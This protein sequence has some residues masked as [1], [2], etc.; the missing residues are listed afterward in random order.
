VIFAVFRISLLRL[1]N[2]KQELLLVF[3]VPVVFFSIFAL[4]F[5]RGVGQSVAQ[6]RVAFVDDDQTS[7]SAAIIRSACERQE[8]RPVTGVGQTVDSWGIERLSKLLISRWD[9]EV[10]IYIPQGFTSQSAEA[11]TLAIELYDEGSN[12]I[13]HRLA[14]AALAESIAM[15][16]SAASLA[17]LN[18]PS[19]Q[20]PFRLTSAVSTGK[21][22][23]PHSFVED[24][25][26]EPTVFRTHNVFASNKHQPKVALVAA[27][28]AVMFLL[29]SANSA[30]ASLLEE[31]EAG[32]LDRLFTTQLSL[33]ELLLG[34]WLFMTLIGFTQLFVMFSWGQLVFNIDLL[35]R[36]PGF[37]MMAFVTAAA[38]ASFALFLA[39][40]SRSRQ[41]LHALSIVFVLSMSAVGGSMVP[42]YIMSDTMR[43]LGKLTFNGWALDG[44]QK[45]FWYDLPVHAIR[46]EV[47][48]LATMAACF[49]L[50]A[51]GF[52]ERWR[53]I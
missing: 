51:R 30:G 31:R 10:V 1:W 21:P 18:P 46:I 42:R 53:W 44:F 3:V 34:K 41:Q 12:P 49:G 19:R 36:L 29:F 4:I 20:S 7:E 9:A 38:C 43:Q 40:V 15:E 28:I 37:A 5:S 33:G 27:G 13:G 39:S 17:N 24:P 8:L 22:V 50:A 16:L 47:A 32:T 45:V 2:N 52:A 26:P 14:Q 11:P 25:Q 35:G 23:D 48:V 6:V